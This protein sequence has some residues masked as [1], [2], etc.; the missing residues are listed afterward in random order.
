VRLLVTGGA[1]FLGAAIVSA[2]VRSGWSVSVLARQAVPARLNGVANAI[3]LHQ[4]DLADREHV[5]AVLARAAPDVVVH[6]AWAGLSGASRSSSDQVTANLLPTLRLVEDAAAAG[7]SKFIGI[8]SQAEYGLLERRI[9]EEDKPAPNSFYGA[10]KLAALHLGRAAAAQ[11]DMAFAWLRLFAAY[12]PG[13]NPH[14]LIPGVVER[15]LGGDSPALTS[16]TQRWDYLYVDDAARGVVA[17]AE[18]SGATGVFNLSSGQA[19]TVR[20]VVE[21]LRSFVAP[22]LPLR[23]GAVPFGPNQIMH[24]EGDNQRLTQA[25][26]WHPLTSLDDGLALT[27]AAI[28]AART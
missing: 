6:S 23:F 21:R 2:A 7:A 15:M 19:E 25:T 12:G 9:S 8:G 24:M 26:G 10:A 13:D 3:R 16:G 5:R 14:W 1:G 20:S 27:V 11:T 28:R 22:D 18:T 17:V 4:V